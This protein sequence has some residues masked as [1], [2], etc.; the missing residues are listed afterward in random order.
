MKFKP[1]IVSAHQPNLLPY[2]GFF[3]KMQKSDILVIR[4]EVLYVKKEYHNRNRIRI[5]SNNQNIP[6]SKWLSV[7][8][9]ESHDY[10]RHIK[11]NRDSKHKNKMLWNE[12]ILHD[13]KANYHKTPFFEVFFPEIE[14]VFDN[15]DED[16]ISLNMKIIR[17]LAKVFNINTKII[18]AS[19][20]NLKPLHYEKSDASQDLV[21]I[22]K[23]LGADIY[24]SGSG[25]KEY[26]NKEIFAK[27]GIELQFQEYNH[28]V[29]TQA[30][31]GFLP[32]ISAI[33]ALFCYGKMPLPQQLRVL[34]T[35][36]IIVS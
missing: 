11:I 8:V 14:K 33:D 16:L 15:S 18:L 32:Y 31:P 26:L 9:E 10:I 5:N 19:E 22:C 27:E 36:E 35:P 29:Y 13:I 4:D 7:P 21:N 1:V 25:G 2:L 12:Y 24:L 20:L 30:F 28:P 23:A 6:Q 3:D 17:F 34:S